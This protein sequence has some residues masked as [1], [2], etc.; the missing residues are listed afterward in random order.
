MKENAH[1][2]VRIMIQLSK[3]FSFPCTKIHKLNV[4]RNSDLLLSLVTIYYWYIKCLKERY[5]FYNILWFTLH[6]DVFHIYKYLRSHWIH[7]SFILLWTEAQIEAYLH[8]IF[9]RYYFI[10]K[11]CHLLAAETMC[12]DIKFIMDC[13]CHFLDKLCVQFIE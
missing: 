13:N 1:K 2:S 10:C 4:N 8:W 11:Q 6:S 5:E 12:I 3:M 9:K 7:F